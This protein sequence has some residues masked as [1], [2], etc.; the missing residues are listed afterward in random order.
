LRGLL[1]G[2]AIR[3]NILGDVS[4]IVKIYLTQD[5]IRVGDFTPG[6]DSF[7]YGSG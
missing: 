4:D 2:Q 1:L 3:L 5:R 7:A 6:G